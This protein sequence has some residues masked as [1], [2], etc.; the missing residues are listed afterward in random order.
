MEIRGWTYG[1]ATGVDVCSAAL[2]LLGLVLIAGSDDARNQTPQC[3]RAREILDL[4]QRRTK[5]AVIGALW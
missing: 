4:A 1:V 3:V 5:E 2:G